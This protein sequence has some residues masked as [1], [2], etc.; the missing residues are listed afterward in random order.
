MKDI[1]LLIHRIPFPPNK[2]DKLR[3]FNLL[4]VLAEH[5]RVHLGT[6]VDNRSDW[7]HVHRLTP[8]CS[9]TCFVPM[10]SVSAT[11]RSARGLLQGAALTFPYYG[12]RR[13]RRWVD[14]IGRHKPLAAAVIFSSSMAQYVLGENFHGLRKVIDFVDVDSDKWQQY[15]EAKSWPLSWIYRREAEKLS[16]AEDDIARNFDASIFVSQAEAQLFLERSPGISHA[17]H[18]VPNG[19]DTDYFDPEIETTRPYSDI[20]KV[21]VFTG[22]M[23]YWANVDAIAWFATEV[24]P[25]IRRQL[26][27]SVLYVVGSNPAAAVRKLSHLP[28]VHVTGTVPDVRPYIAHAH[29]I[30][31][32]LRIARGVQNKVLEGLAMGRPVIATPAAVD[33][34]DCRTIDGVVVAEQ[35][36][37]MVREAIRVLQGDETGDGANERRRFILE[38]YNW[39]KN[40][41]QVVDMIEAA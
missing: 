32:P 34:I 3:S 13:M 37:V 2:G 11:L 26:Q 6:F 36:P 19:V 28:G 4:K 17:V 22:A 16:R 23:D 7:Q 1:L 20:D 18:A 31:A 15:S 25:E 8:Y 38:H 29:A 24:F 14:W 41:G 35:A 5:Y 21:L 12:D 27:D 30:V 40:L 9:E 33:G 10:N 39:Q